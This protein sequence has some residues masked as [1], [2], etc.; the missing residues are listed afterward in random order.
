M[1][2][3]QPLDGAVQNVP[4]ARSTWK[5]LWLVAS[6]IQGLLLVLCLAYVCW[7]Y[8]APPVESPSIQSIRVELIRCEKNRLS[9]FT[10]LNKS[11]TMKVQNNSIVI[12]CDGFYLIYMKGSFFQN[13]KIN[14][15]YRKGW[16]PISIS[17]VGSDHSVNFTAVVYLYYKD[18]VYLDVKTQNTSCEHLQMNYGELILVQL[19]PVMQHLQDGALS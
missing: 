10:P 18:I 11:E 14:L 1:E 6:G 3:V 9:L 17:V 13:V 12:T 2:G 15:H 5:K 19:N 8:Y 16:E 7:H 4:R